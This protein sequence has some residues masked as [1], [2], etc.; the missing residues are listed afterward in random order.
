MFD[1]NLPHITDAGAKDLSRVPFSINL[2]HLTDVGA[3]RLA[4]YSRELAASSR[5]RAEA[6]AS[7]KRALETVAA[8]RLVTGVLALCFCALCVHA[9]KA[10]RAAPT[11]APGPRRAPAPVADAGNGNSR[12]P[13]RGDD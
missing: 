7:L 2:P 3:R 6:A 8:R 10:F 11:P 12:P 1:I 4:G 13:A 9:V 5:H